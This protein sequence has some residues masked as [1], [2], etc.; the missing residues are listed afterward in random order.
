LLNQRAKIRIDSFI[1]CQQIVALRFPPVKTGLF[2]KEQFM[3]N[4]E[5]LTPLLI[6][7][8]VANFA[9]W[10][11]PCFVGRLAFTSPQGI[12]ALLFSSS[13]WIP[14]ITTILNPHGFIRPDVQV[15]K[16]NYVA[17]A[18]L[19]AG[20]GFL[21]SY[22]F[23]RMAF[24]DNHYRIGTNFRVSALLDAGKAQYL[25]LIIRLS[26]VIAALLLAYCFI[27]ALSMTGTV[28]RRTF[29]LEDRPFWRFTVMKIAGYFIGTTN[30]LYFIVSTNKKTRPTLTILM[31]VNTYL[32]IIVNGF[33]GGRASSGFALFLSLMGY[34]FGIKS[35]NVQ[36]K[37]FR[38]TR[39]KTLILLLI[40]SLFA[41]SIFFQGRSNLIGWN[42]AG[43]LNQHLYSSFILLFSPTPTLH[44]ST[45]MAKH[46]ETYGT[47]GY[48]SYLRDIG[49]TLVPEFLVGTYYFG[50]PIVIQ[51]HNEL[52]LWGRDFGTLG[53]AIYSGGIAGCFFIHL[54]LGLIANHLYNSWLKGKYIYGIFYLTFVLAVLTSVRSSMMQFLKVWIYVALVLTLIYLILI[55]KSFVFRHQKANTALRRVN[56]LQRKNKIYKI[57]GR[58][59][60]HSSLTDH[61]D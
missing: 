24:S 17:M 47:Q 14:I 45:I 33:D 58:R 13:Y 16:F 46:I 36:E 32:L 54:M 20:M 31:F 55:K 25:A 38:K 56:L 26:Y 9:I 30:F 52:G 28:D 11:L 27:E 59:L 35:F 6:S 12:V 53:Q 48:Q 5:L 57:Q 1:V 49:N 60:F 10:M 43:E 2:L 61:S 51:I 21:I 41:M 3:P 42:F 19:L 15:D 7:L 39:L 40:P 37:R 29:F 44:I 50:T 34:L 8:L 18:S 23:Y 4:L 22:F